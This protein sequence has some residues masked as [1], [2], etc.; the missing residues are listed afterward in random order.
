MSLT[1]PGEKQN[2]DLH[3]LGRGA[4]TNHDDGTE[5][6]F[7]VVRI[8]NT[9]VPRLWTI[10]I[11]LPG[12]ILDNAGH[13]SAE[14][15]A[16]LACQIARAA[17]IFCVDEVVIFREGARLSDEDS[18]DTLAL[19]LRYMDTPQ[20]LRRHLFPVSDKLK[21]VGSLNPLNLP[22]HFAKED[23]PR[24]RDGV[25]VPAG[26][27]FSG[28]SKYDS[29]HSMKRDIP[30]SRYVD[31]GLQRLVEVDKPVPLYERVTIDMSASGHG[32]DACPGKYLFGQVVPRSTPRKQDGLY[33]GFTVRVAD[34]LL[35]ALGCPR[36]QDCDEEDDNM[37]DLVVGTSER[38]S[39]VGAL[40]GARSGSANVALPEFCRGLVVFGGVHGLEH[41]AQ[42]DARLAEQNM[43]SEAANA[44]PIGDLFDFY[45]NTCPRQGSRTIRT[46]EA[47][48]ISLAVLQPYLRP[49]N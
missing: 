29:E 43:G 39:P 41:S 25:A 36:A 6:S 4:P 21:Y 22:N 47:I 34:S 40:G 44:V 11:A 19:L 17:A 32:Y 35:G 23:Q 1:M 31:V 48:P 2:G 18:T 15:Q 16:S 3:M 14:L 12:S 9:N 5:C 33:W 49:R 45:L 46:E 28:R 10:S 8:E 30:M 7:D 24:W 42:C 38:G 26:R 27:S 13:K 20:Y 37:Y